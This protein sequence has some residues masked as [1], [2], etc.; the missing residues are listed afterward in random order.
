MKPS[1]NFYNKLERFKDWFFTDSGAFLIL[2]LSFIAK[3]ISYIHN[4]SIHPYE[5][6]PYE[7][8]PFELEIS[9]VFW[10][11]IWIGLGILLFMSVFLK[12]TWFTA[13]V[14]ALAMGFL[15]IW[16]SGFALTGNFFITQLGALPLG[17]MAMSIY[18]VKRG[19]DRRIEIVNKSR[20][21]TDEFKL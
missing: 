17:Y 3:G 13:T 15:F 12:K 11:D 7:H 2:S 18:A 10:S 9:S 6:H 1:E 8:H 14:F 4:S 16:G 5:H 20:E 21:D 19:R